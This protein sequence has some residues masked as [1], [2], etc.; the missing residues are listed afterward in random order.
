MDDSQPLRST[1][2]FCQSRLFFISSTE[3][4]RNKLHLDSMPWG[5]CLPPSNCCLA[6][7]SS[8]C[9]T[10]PALA[11]TCCPQQK[12]HL[13]ALGFVQDLPHFARLL[14]GG[15]PAQLPRA[16]PHQTGPTLHG[17]HLTVKGSGSKMARL[18][19]P[20]IRCSQQ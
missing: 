1:Q 10:L 5:V 4:S 11:V 13:H 16:A 9:A 18:A 6:Q 15:F 2:A 7:P 14:L 19:A 8:A 12:V 3:A 20:H 17:G